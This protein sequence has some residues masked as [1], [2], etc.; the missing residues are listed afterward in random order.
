MPVFGPDPLLTVQA[1][2]TVSTFSYSHKVPSSKLQSPWFGQLPLV[3]LT[4]SIA[5][6]LILRIYFFLTK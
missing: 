1:I 6:Q 2:S 5:V 3:I 4:S